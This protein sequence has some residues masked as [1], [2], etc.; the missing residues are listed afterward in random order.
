[1]K[2]FFQS[3]SVNVFVDEIHCKSHYSSKC[4]TEIKSIGDCSVT[5]GSE[6]HQAASCYG[7]LKIV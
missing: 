2:C 4:H 3:L 7:G 5:Q 1:M 6:T